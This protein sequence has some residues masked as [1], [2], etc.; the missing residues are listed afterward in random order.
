[1]GGVIMAKRI[2]PGLYDAW[3]VKPPCS[4]GGEC[5]LRCPYSSECWGSPEEEEDICD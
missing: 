2:S 5:D 1:M 4:N 3:K